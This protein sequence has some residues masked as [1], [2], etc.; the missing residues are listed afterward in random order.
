MFDK[1]QDICENIVNASQFGSFITYEQDGL[2]AKLKIKPASGEE[3]SLGKLLL[4]IAEKTITYI[5]FDSNKSDVFFLP[6]AVIQNLAIRD[7]VQINEHTKKDTI[8]RYT[9]SVRKL[10]E[11]GDFVNL[12]QSGYGLMILLKKDTVKCEKLKF[13]KRENKFKKT[14]E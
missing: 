12:H 7:T 9:L 6:W 1:L 3:K 10:C 4:D 2:C 13:S 11:K 14:E 8:N 5:K